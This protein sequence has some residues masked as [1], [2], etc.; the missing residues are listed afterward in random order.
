MPSETSFAK[1]SLYDNSTDKTEKFGSFRA[2]LAGTDSTSNMNKI[3]ALLKS[4]NDSITA[5][6]TQ[7]QQ[8]SDNADTHFG[9]IDANLLAL[10]TKDAEHDTAITNLQTKDTELETSVSQKATTTTYTVS[11]DPTAWGSSAPYIQ[12]ITV[13]G[14]TATDNPIAGVTPT[15]STLDAK[16]GQVKAWSYISEITTAD[17]SITLTCYDKKPTISFVIQLKVVR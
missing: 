14:I 2:A 8:V 15:G 17:N 16:K 7:I 10:Q 11:T 6:G 12:T 13:V 9:T 4:H 1:L 3:D 5:L